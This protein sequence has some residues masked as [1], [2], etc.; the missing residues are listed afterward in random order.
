VLGVASACDWYSREEYGDANNL[1]VPWT[2]ISGIYGDGLKPW[3]LVNPK[4]AGI[5][6]CSSH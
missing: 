6:G 5:Y 2:K 1:W 3:Y 4:I